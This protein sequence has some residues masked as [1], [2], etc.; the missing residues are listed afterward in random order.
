MTLNDVAREAGVSKSTVSLVV[1]NSPKVREETRLKVE[2]AI[3]KLH[4]TPNIAAKELTTN[5]KMSM[6]IIIT[7]PCEMPN[8][9]TFD[10]MDDNYFH[11]VERGILK[12]L[13]NEDYGLLIEQFTTSGENPQK[14]PNIVK[15]RRIEGLFVVGGIFDPLFIKNLQRYDIPLVIM[16]RN[17]EGIDCVTTDYEYATYIGVKYLIEQGHRDILYVSGP[18][19][20]PSSEMKDKG[21]FK[22]LK[23]ANIPIRDEF[24][25]ESDFTGLGGYMAVKEAIEKRKIKPTAIFT[26]VDANAV[27]AMRYFY[28]KQIRIP[29]DMSIMSYDDSLLAEY[30][31][32][33]L[34]SVHINK[35][36]IGQM[37]A[38]L[39]L[40]RMKD[41]DSATTNVIVPVQIVERE[42]VSWNKKS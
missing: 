30:A 19:V 23:E 7:N 6:G 39:L 24:Y 31:T 38:K 8:R 42:S 36:Q 5:K 40:K 41:R 20:T 25:T 4:Y 28:E 32:P 34:T 21:V 1:N 17:Y 12:A 27:G 15:K 11:D 35:E 3:K 14:V 18:K 26:S 33:P 13:E 29:R 22:A 9:T 2:K 37:G 10:M 16:G